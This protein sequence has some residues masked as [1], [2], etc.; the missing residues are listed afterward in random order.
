MRT[1]E[2]VIK[3]QQNIEGRDEFI[4]RN[5]DFIRRCASLTAKRFINENDDIFSEA[6]I[7]FN[8]AIDNYDISK[9]DFFAFAKTVI[10]NKINDWFKKQ[11]R[12]S[13]VIS[14]SGLT[15]NDDE[16]KEIEIEDKN[17]GISDTAFEIYSLGQELEKFEISFF[18]LPKSSPKSHKTREACMLVVNYI[19]NNEELLRYVYSKKCLPVKQIIEEL[20]V[21]KKIPD[22]YRK[23]IITGIVIINGKYDIV[24]EYFN[25]KVG[26]CK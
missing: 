9:G 20:K 14:F 12:H 15:S 21:N 11:T 24:S 7:A 22:R 17:A 3:V 25:P 16:E 8:D 5:V 19:L 10:H 6:L 26:R 4:K 13:K 18:D 1:N 2:E 23:Y